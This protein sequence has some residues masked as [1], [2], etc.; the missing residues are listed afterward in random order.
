[1]QVPVITNCPS[2]INETTDP[3]QPSA[4][5]SW[6]E[7]TV[8]DNSGSFSIDKSH[9]PLSLFPAGTTELVYLVT[10]NSSNLAMCIFNI[11]VTGKLLFG[12]FLTERKP[13]G[14]YKFLVS[15]R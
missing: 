14:I 2:D 13:T 11:T 8:S 4:N 6:S 12:V 9:V 5:I 7:P 10:D 3:G 1:M 15:E